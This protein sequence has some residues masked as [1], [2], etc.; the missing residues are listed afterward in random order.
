[1]NVSTVKNITDQAVKNLFAHQSNIFDF[2]SETN[3]TE[4][5]LAHHLAVEMHNLLP[6]FDYDLDVTKINYDRKR[7]DIIFHK[8]GNND[9]N[10]LVVEIK[11]D[12]SDVDLD[13]DEEK[14]KRHWFRP[15]LSYAFGVVINLRS[16][17]KWDITVL[18]NN[19][20]AI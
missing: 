3:Q 19:G 7:P 5:N 17:T 12:G 20:E 16:K 14:I 18:E 1:M 13:K 4:W 9:S 8:R 11:K 2:T 15:P 10:F 6:W